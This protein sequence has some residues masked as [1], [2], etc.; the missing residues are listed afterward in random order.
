MIITGKPY[1]LY[2]ALFWKSYV[3]QMRPYLLFVS[4]IAGTAGMAMSKTESTESWKLFVAFFPFFMGYGFGQ[5]L[6]DCFQTDTDKLSAPYRPLSKGAVSVKAVL[7][8]SLAGLLFCAAAFYSL[9]KISFLLSGLAVFGL[10][11]Y[12]YFKKNITFAGPFYNAWIVTLLPLMGYFSLADIVTKSFPSLYLPYLLVSFFS[13]A[14]FVLIGYLKDIDADR[15]TGYKTFPV[16][17]GWKKTVILG[18][19]FALTTLCCFWLAAKHNLHETAVGIAAS[20]TILYGQW[21][22]HLAKNENVETALHPILATVRSFILF[23]IAI[24]LH[25][26]MMWWLY[27]V[28]YY[29]LFEVFLFTRPSR[30]QV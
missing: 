14:S 10:A 26:Q 11:T 6:T 5:A 4:G 21:K 30:C 18:D 16:V 28:V 23:H 1:P 2:S 3:V 19:V 29:L 22:G 17:W 7:G 12:S 20:L 8:V 9:H 13:Y 25:F 15:A 27:T 24:V